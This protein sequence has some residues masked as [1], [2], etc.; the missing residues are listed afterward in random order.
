M[1]KTVF[2]IL[3]LA[4]AVISGVAT[5]QTNE[6]QCTPI[7][8][9]DPN[10][11]VI[12]GNLASIE[13]WPSFA[14]ISIRP[15]DD[16][17]ADIHICGATA[18]APRWLLTAAHCVD[19]AAQ[20]EWSAASGE[21]V[22][23]LRVRHSMVGIEGHLFAT[24]NADKL[25]ENG[26]AEIIAI[27][28]VIIHEDYQSDAVQSNDIA[29]LKLATKWDGAIGRVGLTSAYKALEGRAF[30][31]GFGYTLDPREHDGSDDVVFRGMNQLTRADGSPYLAGSENLLAAIVPPVS[32]NL[33]ALKNYGQI[34]RETEFCAGFR[35]GSRD[36]CNTDSG[37]PIVQ[38]DREGCPYL[39]GIVQSGQWCG[40][41]N[42]GDA[43]F[44]IYTRL[45]AYDDFII[46]TVGAIQLPV[47]PPETDQQRMLS[48][49]DK[50]EKW[51]ARIPDRVTLEMHRT[52]RPGAGEA[53]L[54]PR[55]NSFIDQDGMHIT[56]STTTPGNVSVIDM[57]A[58]GTLTQI[59]STR[60]SAEDSSSESTQT[61]RF[62]GRLPQEG[63]PFR[64]E[65]PYGE[66]RMMLLVSPDW[67]ELDFGS[68]ALRRED[69]SSQIL[70]KL[71]TALSDEQNSS[72][73]KG[74][75]I[76]IVPYRITPRNFGSD[77]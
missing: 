22:R 47:A 54:D 27:E 45:A 61:F 74:W 26:D 68:A 13:E 77:R 41:Q 36:S 34:D 30:V 11:R 25:S 29:L 37:G 1:V 40:A 14:S 21:N 28:D 60:I 31:A 12:G 72:D 57:N 2:A 69:P 50:I 70:D 15:E 52:A 75:G 33:C 44:G 32:D 10:D 55:P 66:G 38:I 6:T 64:A 19:K 9:G 62:D 76:A 71:A 3:V 58:N 46:D 7:T 8:A 20:E 49:S 51:A 17:Q 16:D 5:A 56:F 4:S 48:V 42:D 59:Y 24:L 39:V 65:E 23:S 67:A 63:S 35:T 73:Y 43:S 18:I 53:E